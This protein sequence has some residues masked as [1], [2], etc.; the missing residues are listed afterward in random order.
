MAIAL[1]ATLGYL[2]LSG[3]GPAMLAAH[4]LALKSDGQV[5]TLYDTGSMEPSLTAKDV[6]VFEPRLM[7]DVRV[8]DV[9][10]YELEPKYQAVSGGIKFIVHRVVEKKDDHLVTK[11]DA[12]GYAD[13]WTVAE[14]QIVGVMTSSIR[15]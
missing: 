4:Y 8:G 10:A 9:V 6:L 15:F 1:I 13:P 7:T 2:V 12:N 3:K 11:G 5:F 14:H